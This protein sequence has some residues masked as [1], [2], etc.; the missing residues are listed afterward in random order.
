V[1][2]H[3]RQKNKHVGEYK[4]CIKHSTESDYTSRSYITLETIY[5]GLGKN[6]TSRTTMATQL[7]NNANGI[8]A[9]LKVF[10]VINE[11]KTNEKIICSV[12]VARMKM[13]R[14]SLYIFRPR[15]AICL[16]VTIADFFCGIWT[17]CRCCYEE[18][19]WQLNAEA[20]GVAKK[21]T[22]STCTP[23][24]EKIFLA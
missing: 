20:T 2:E 11:Y 19:T 9:K 24:A 22:G 3:I 12:I 6:L 18:I 17:Y 1:R 4:R 14:I 23:R 8:E 7:R 5:S 15:N 10:Y 13:R 16:T 21:C